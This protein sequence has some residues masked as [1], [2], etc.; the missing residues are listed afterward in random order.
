MNDKRKKY[1]QNT[2]QTRKQILFK[3]NPQTHDALESMNIH[4][5]NV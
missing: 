4:V 5:Q 2:D 1:L 3:K